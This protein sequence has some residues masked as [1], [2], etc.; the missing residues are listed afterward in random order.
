[1]R[2]DEVSAASHGVPILW[3]KVFALSVA[4]FLAGIAGS[5]YG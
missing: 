3:Y 1:V 4:A 5:L 2:E